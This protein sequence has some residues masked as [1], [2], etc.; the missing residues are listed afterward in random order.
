M[1]VMFIVKPNLSSIS[2]ILIQKLI[3]TFMMVDISRNLVKMVQV[4][5]AGCTA[6]ARAESELRDTHICYLNRMEDGVSPV[7]LLFNLVLEDAIRKCNIQRIIN[8]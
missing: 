6:L 3:E 5:M 7:G 8:V 4:T 1:L 2:V